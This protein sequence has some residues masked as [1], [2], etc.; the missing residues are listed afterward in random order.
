VLKSLLSV[1]PALYTGQTSW[2]YSRISSVHQTCPISYPGCREV[3]RTCPTLSS[4]L[5][6]LSVLTRVK[7]LEPN[8]SSSK[9]GFQRDFLNMSSR[10]PDMFGEL[11][12]RCNL[13]ST[14]LIRPFSRHVWVLTQ[15]CHLREI[16]SVSDLSRFGVFIPV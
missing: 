15:L 1:R 12:D 11:Y 3:S 7:S 13:N 9:A 2:T 5:S 4:D 6:G 16:S 14:G 8:M 10:G